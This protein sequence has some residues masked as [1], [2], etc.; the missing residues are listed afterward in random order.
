MLA[1]AAA[2][3]GGIFPVNRMAADA[4]WPAL[5]FAFAQAL[6]GGILLAGY[7]LARRQPLVPSVR[8]A[9][10]YLLLGALAMGLPTALLTWS[11]GHVPAST[12]TVVLSLSPVFTLVFAIVLRLEPFRLRALAAVLLGLCGVALIAAP[13]SRG[14]QAGALPWFL[15]AL[16][17]PVLFAAS[18]VVASWLRPPAT[19]STTMAAG[20]LLGG[21]CV[22]ALVMLPANRTVLP[23][24]LD[25][26]AIAPLVLAA[27]IDGATFVLFFEIVRRAGPTFFSLFN[28]LAIGAGIAWS[29]L[30]FAEVPPP[31][32]WP[33]L[34][35][36]LAAV[37]TAVGGRR[38]P[39]PA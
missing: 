4:G 22:L 38:V 10:V 19:A 33:A 1:A 17:A 20:I 39:A 29:M 24:V 16:L 34:V 11:A 12:L 7:V 21:V 5:G 2:I 23:D 25:G 32:F 8:H 31:V 30:A 28:Y 27:V 15:L 18:N 9:A 13:G 26:G 36:M 35:V 14:L 37:Y 3:Y 6:L